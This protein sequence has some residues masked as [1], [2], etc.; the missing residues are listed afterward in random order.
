MSNVIESPRSDL[1]LPPRILVADDNL[2]N[3]KVALHMLSQIGVPHEN[4]SF[5]D[6]GF[7]ALS[8]VLA[9]ADL[10]SNELPFDIIFMDVQMPVMDGFEAVRAIRKL[11]T[12]KQIP[13]IAMTAHAMT[14]DKERCLNEGMDDYICKPLNL[15]K[16]EGL[17]NHWTTIHNGREIDEK[18]SLDVDVLTNLCEGDVDFEREI[19]QAYL[20]SAP[21]MIAQCQV[22]VELRNGAGLEHWSHTL[23]SSCRTIGANDLAEIC[24]RLETTGKMDNLDDATTLQ[25]INSVM[26]EFAAE[27]VHVRNDINSCLAALPESSPCLAKAS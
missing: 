12:S 9:E 24:Q 18:L 27:A 21:A 8:I 16:L 15:Q 6:N 14:G 2:I 23:K 13:I 4:I 17:L 11:K 7:D 3:Q 22:M 25:Q 19:L 1:K 20:R 5:V 10:R 26:S